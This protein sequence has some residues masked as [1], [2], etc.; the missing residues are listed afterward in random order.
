MVQVRVRDEV[1]LIDAWGLSNR[2][3]LENSSGG[4]N[5]SFSS[6]LD[7]SLLQGIDS[8]Q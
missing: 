8:K 6:A 1:H 2:G 4:S 3:W 5:R 7:E